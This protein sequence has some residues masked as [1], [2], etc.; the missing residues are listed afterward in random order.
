MAFWKLNASS[1]WDAKSWKISLWIGFSHRGCHIY[2]E[3][4]TIY[5]AVFSL[6]GIRGFGKSR[7]ESHSIF[8]SYPDNFDFCD[9]EVLVSKAE[10]SLQGTQQWFHWIQRGDF[11]LV[12]PNSLCHW[13]NREKKITLKEKKNKTSLYWGGWW[14]FSKVIALHYAVWA[15]WTLLGTKAVLWGSPLNVSMPNNKC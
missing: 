4:E 5:M 9:L 7:T 15:R 2:F 1:S 13:T 3:S 14:P 8:T 11:Y 12:F 6:A 10:C